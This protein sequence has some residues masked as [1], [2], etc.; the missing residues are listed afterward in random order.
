[1]CDVL[2]KMSS[3]PEKFW[4]EHWAEVGKIAKEALRENRHLMRPIYGI[5]ASRFRDRIYKHFHRLGRLVAKRKNRITL[6]DDRFGYMFDT[7]DWSHC[8][9]KAVDMFI[10]G[11]KDVRGWKRKVVA[12]IYLKEFFYFVDITGSEQDKELVVR[13]L[14]DKLNKVFLEEI[15]WQRLQTQGS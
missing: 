4:R 8:E 6:I 3:D 11:Y 5:S 10:E 15:K 7:S 1:M 2:E 14:M 9:N 12:G 13:Q